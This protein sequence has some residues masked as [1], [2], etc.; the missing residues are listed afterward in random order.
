[1]SALQPLIEQYLEG[2]KQLRQAVAGMSR[3][4]ALARPIAGKWSTLEVVCHLADF[5]PILAD[6][7]KRVIAE[8]KP[9]LV[10]ADEQKFAAALCYQDR[11]L[12]EELTIIEATRSQLARILKRLPDAALHR[13]GEHSERGPRTLEQLLKGAIDHLPHHV[14]FILDKRQALGLK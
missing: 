8:E 5:D 12:Q 11:D 2:P 4:Q 3:E 6:R 14:K 10:G 9:T 1:M 7:M 13:L